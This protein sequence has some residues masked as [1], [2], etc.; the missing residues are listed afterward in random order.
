LTT[1]LDTNILHRNNKIRLAC[2]STYLV[3]ITNIEN[4]LPHCLKH[5]NHCPFKFLQAIRI[6]LTYKVQVP[7]L[8]PVLLTTR[9]AL[10]RK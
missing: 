2:M 9:S 1:Y 7:H 3:I 4:A 10:L 8:N 6:L 5:T